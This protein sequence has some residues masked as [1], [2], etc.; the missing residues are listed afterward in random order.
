M[1]IFLLI[2]S[3][4]FFYFFFKVDGNIASGKTEFAKKLAESFDLLYIPDVHPD[5]VWL[6]EEGFD[7]RELD[8]QFSVGPNKSYDLEKFFTDKNAKNLRV[9][10]PQMLLYHKRFFNYVR[11][12]EHMLN[13]GEY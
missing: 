13:T 7:M 5:E 2:K 6:N 12:L 1:N 4:I 9:G 11:A 8:D 10:R 3:Y